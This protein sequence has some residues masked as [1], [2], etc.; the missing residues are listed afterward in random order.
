MLPERIIHDFMCFL[1]T[2]RTSSYLQKDSWII[3]SGSIMQEVGIQVVSC[4]KKYKVTADS[5]HQ[6]PVFEN[7]LNRQFD[8]AKRDQIY[9][10]D[11]TYIWMQEGCLYLAIVLGNC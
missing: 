11:I 9:F 5:N 1:Y 7:R 4:R 6:L 2:Y 3:R 10:C 8:V